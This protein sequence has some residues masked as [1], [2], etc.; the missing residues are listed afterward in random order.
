LR[1]ISLG[2]IGDAE[3]K[4][5]GPFEW[6]RL[7]RLGATAE[8]PRLPRHPGRQARNAGGLAGVGYRVDSLR[9]RRSQHEIDAVAVDQ[10][11]RQLPGARRIRLRIT[12]QNLDLVGLA[13]GRDAVS[14]DFT[15]RVQN[16]TVRLAEASKSSR[17]RRDETDPDHVAGLRP[18]GTARCRKC[19]DAGQ[20]RFDETTAR[21]CGKSLFAGRRVC[22]TVCIHVILPYLSRPRFCWAVRS[23][24]LLLLDLRLRPI[25]R[26]DE[27]SQVPCHRQRLLRRR[28]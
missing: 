14:E 24:A 8:I 10:R 6:R 28:P 5:I 11:L 4:V 19:A 12:V 7:T 15:R 9:R 26:S 23:T 3:A 2:E 20:R 18:A 22:V 1:D 21:Y 27:P 13:P 25:V 17:T 16:E